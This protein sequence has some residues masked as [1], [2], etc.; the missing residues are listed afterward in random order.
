ME[1]IDLYTRDK[2]RTKIRAV[3][4]EDIPAGYYQLIVFVCIFNREGRML[5][6]QRSFDKKECPGVWDVSVGGGVQAGE[7]SAMAAARETGE[8]LGLTI[9]FEQ[10]C[11]HLT[12]YYERCIHDIYIVR[13]DVK[14]EALRLMTEEV[15]QVMWA[16]E[17]RIGQM[18][19][20]GEFLNVSRA[21]IRMLF[22]MQYHR[23]IL[24]ADI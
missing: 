2:Q 4:G 24:A 1:Y 19:D 5:I 22:E 20:G 10:S 8:E 17:E 3:R 21:F 15:N 13:E 11:P 14:I 6:Q 9:D 12:L 16:D 18:I 7:T 23:G